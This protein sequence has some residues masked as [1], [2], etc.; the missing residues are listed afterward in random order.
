M[1][2]VKTSFKETLTPFF[3]ISSLDVFSNSLAIG[4]NNVEIVM[5]PDF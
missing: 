5:I 1:S 3:K 4:K 2:K